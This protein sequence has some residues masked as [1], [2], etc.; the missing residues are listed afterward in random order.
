MTRPWWWGLLGLLL[1]WSALAEVRLTLDE[2][3]ERALNHD[4]RVSEQRHLVDAARALLEE[5]MGHGALRFEAN[6]FVGLTRGLDGGFFEGGREACVALPCSPRDDV[7]SFDDGVSLWGNLEFRI[8]KPL[9]TFGK[10]ENYSAAA[11]GKVDVARGDV[12]LRRRQVRLDVMGAYWGFLTAR[13]TR[14]L[15]EDVARRMDAALALGEQRL[16]EDHQGIRPSDVYALRT[17]KALVQRYL[18]QARSVE[19]IAREGLRLLTG[20]E[21]EENFSVVDEH[22]APVDMPALALAELQQQALQK[23][24]EMA[25]LEAGLRAR[26]ALVAAHKAEKLPDV[27]VGVT[28]SASYAPGRDRL[29]NPHVFDPFNYAVVTPMVGLRWEWLSGTQPAK[30]AHA[31][32]ELNALLDKAAFARD[33]IPFEVAEAYH[34]AAG[35]REALQHVRSGSRHGRRWMMGRHADFQ[36]GEEEASQVLEAFQG[37]VSAHMDY[38]TLVND[39]NMEVARLL[40]AAGEY[41]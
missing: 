10:I 23:R 16:S 7:Y 41:R 25:Q 12:E 35:L 20:L 2:A 32:A 13:D 19:T 21:A 22:I 8:V 27:Y 37:Y 5:A 17:G 4:P 36:A 9:F 6:T 1:T 33:G 28:G 3:V 29:D 31:Q 18:A 39:Y 26:R 30:V 24:P 40:N 34:T 15:L 38:L 11:Q 14:Y